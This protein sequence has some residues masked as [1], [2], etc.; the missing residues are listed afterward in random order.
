MEKLKYIYK[1]LREKY[2]RQKR[3][4][5]FS[6]IESKIEKENLTIICNNCFAGRLY[7]DL[8]L[9]YNTPTVGL[10]IMFPDFNEFVSN[11]EYY[12]SA[13]LTFVH[14]SKYQIGNERISNAKHKYPI[15]LL[16]GKIE[17]HFLHYKSEEEALNKW[18]RRTGR[19]NLNNLI[20]IGSEQNNCKEEDI[21][22]FDKIPFKRKI[23]FSTKPIQGNSI[24]YVPEFNNYEEAGDPFAKADIYYK[25]LV[26]FFQ[27]KN[28]K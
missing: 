22:G 28:W 24:V 19:I 1:W 3:I 7:Q 23:F 4:K 16:D 11:I 18:K 2:Y 26:E 15:A 25:Y 14:Q 8:N 5:Y 27:D 21:L 6:S 10:Y 17:I 20:V 12:Q 9:S 13:D